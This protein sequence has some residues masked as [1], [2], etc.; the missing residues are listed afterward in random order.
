MK[1]ALS[2]SAYQEV[3]SDGPNAA[4][5]DEI[6]SRSICSQKNRRVWQNGAALPSMD[7]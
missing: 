2:V 6:G 3:S 1:T 7:T 4:S 5:A